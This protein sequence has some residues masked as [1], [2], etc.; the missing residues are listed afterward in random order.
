MLG[1]LSRGCQERMFWLGWCGHTSISYPR[2]PSYIYISCRELLWRN[3]SRTRRRNFYALRAASTILL[4]WPKSPNGRRIGMQWW[5][6]VSVSSCFHYLRNM[7][8][9]SN[10][11]AL[12]SQLDCFDSRLPG[13]GVFDI[14]TRA[15]MTIRHD[16]LNFEESSGY[17]IHTLQG[18]VESFEKE[19]Y[20][21]IRSAFLK[22]RWALTK[23]GERYHLITRAAFKHE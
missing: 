23:V 4:L 22:Y 16:L 21:L 7:L 3:F 8:S 9:Q 6:S 14:K 5:V 18:L 11:F 17:Q 10:K 1:T 15:V 12:R 2:S 13:T 19:Y 20:D